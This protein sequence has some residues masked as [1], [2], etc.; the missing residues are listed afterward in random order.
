MPKQ[1]CE[2]DSTFYNLN[3]PSFVSHFDETVVLR[4]VQG[5][6]SETS[7]HHL[8]GHEDRRRAQKCYQGLI[9]IESRGA[10]EVMLGKRHST[11]C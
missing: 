4:V 11:A 1:D 8:T 10:S 7:V 6:L 3:T 5:D 2:L 9:W